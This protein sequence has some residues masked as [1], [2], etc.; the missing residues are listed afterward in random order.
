MINPVAFSIFGHDIRWYGI[1]IAMALLLGIL[2]A[3]YL[4]KRE[5]RDP[6]TVLDLALVV[7]PLAV[8]CARIYYVIFTW[9]E[10][11][12]KQ[13]FWH[14]FAIWEGGLAIYGAVIGGA[15]GVWLYSRFSKNKIK[16][17]PLLDILAPSLILGQAIGRWGNFVNQEAFGNLI[18]NPS[19]QWFPAAVYIEAP[20][21][22]N[23]IEP[24]GWYMATF[25]YE[26]VWNFLVFAFLLFYI[27]KAKQR[28]PGN[29]FWLYLLGYGIGRL[30][31]EGLRTDS[32]MMGDI[33]V[34]Q[35]LS[36]LFIV[37]A[38]VML[39]LPYINKMLGRAKEREVEAEGK[40]LDDSLKLILDED[41]DTLLTDEE[42]GDGA[43]STHT[44]DSAGGDAPPSNVEE[45]PAEAGNTEEGS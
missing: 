25:F 22:G 13:E 17:L 18:T 7:V 14:V 26:S 28:K 9:N 31:I 35:W 30:V 33:R 15:I 12:S 38:G 21:I 8:I 39:L 24:A 32:L 2:L 41:R 27:T 11:Y 20:V 16:F 10:I 37:G 5:G 42:A 34:S 23:M 43:A 4:T 1:I 40:P 3:M 44:E 19:W 6:D 45:K 29:V 36:G